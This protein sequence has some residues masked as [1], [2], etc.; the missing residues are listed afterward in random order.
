MDKT[1]LKQINAY[2]REVKSYLICDSK[3]KKKFT[4]DFRDNIY[5]YLEETDINNIDIIRKHFGEPE[6]IAKSFLIEMDIKAV[7][8]RL[9]FKK[10]I[11]TI[12]IVITFIAAV[13]AGIFITTI[14]WHRNDSTK[15]HYYVESL[16]ENGELV[17]E[18][19]GRVEFGD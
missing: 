16:Y 18:E 13:A 12:V 17:K 8:K 15:T 10:I 7:K 5:S 2:V 19:K 14:V 11:S 6:Q 3:T 1:L 9:E 4:D